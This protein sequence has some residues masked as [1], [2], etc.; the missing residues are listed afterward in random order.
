MSDENKQDPLGKTDEDNPG[1]GKNVGVFLLKVVG[2][3]LILIFG[4]IGVL[5]A[6]GGNEMSYVVKE[7]IKA[8]PDRIYK[9]ITEPEQIKKWVEGVKEIRE[10][11]ESKDNEE[12]AEDIKG[13]KVGAMAEVVV[14]APDGTTFKIVDEV[15][16]ARRN[17]EIEL[18]MTADMFDVVQGFKLN[19]KGGNGLATDTVVVTQTYKVRFKGL[20]RVFAPFA[21]TAIEGQLKKNLATLKKLAEDDQ[22]DSSDNG[23]QKQKSDEPKKGA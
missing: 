4:A 20:Y 18:K 13:N 17:Q 9:L 3:A 10:I 11:D 2:V 8:K 12:I 21:N 22:P 16:K 5:Y 7:E 15:T 14:E 1:S 6:V 23:K 19:Y